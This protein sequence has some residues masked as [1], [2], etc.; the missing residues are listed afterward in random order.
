MADNPLTDEQLLESPIEIHRHP[1]PEPERATAV[2]DVVSDIE[3]EPA[4]EVVQT[5]GGRWQVRVSAATRDNGHIA[6]AG[7]EAIRV[8]RA[9][10]AHDL[11][12]GVVGD[13]SP[14]LPEHL[15]D[16]KVSPRLIEADDPF[17]IRFGDLRYLPT[18][19][20]PPEG[21]SIYYDTAYPW[22]CLVRITTPEG[23]AGSGVL[24]GP[25]H[26][27]TASHCIDW[28]A[29]WINWTPGWV[30]AD[31]LYT[32]GRSLAQANGTLIYYE[33]KVGDPIS[34]EESDE[35]YA[36]VVLDQRLGDR[37]GWL[38]ART[39][40][41]DWDD[42]QCSWRSIG[43]PADFSVTGDLAVYQRDFLLN[44][45]GWD[46]GS[47]RLIRSDTFDNF[48]GQSG[49]PVFGFWHDG[50]YAVGVVS[51]ESSD[52]NYISGGS[53]LAALVNRARADNP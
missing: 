15:D 45:L 33:S 9:E 12:G 35:D 43:Y 47:A 13:L 23:W 6:R 8:P 42:E 53:L 28:T 10:L 44:E 19:M 20:F 11:A 26:V 22:R 31:V 17:T 52:Y 3:A 18:T 39:Y 21:R 1:P 40:N 41:S 7:P 27:L 50:P 36:V 24:I 49:S 4:V 14:S 48:K 29:N 46:Y 38:G 2:F 30:Q 37:Y 51:G 5:A 25:R 16:L 34:D 32:N